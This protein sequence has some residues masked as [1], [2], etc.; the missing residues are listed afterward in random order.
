M[1]RRVR[2]AAATLLLGV[3]GNGC[4]G[5]APPAPPKEEARAETP[6]LRV[7]VEPIA[8]GGL[9]E[10]IVVRGRVLPDRDVTFSAETAGRVEALTVDSGDRVRKGEVLARI[11]YALQV[12]QREQAAAGHE[13]AVKTLER[14][15]ALRAD[16]M[17]SQQELDQ[18][19]TQVRTS[20]AA[21]AIA[22]AQLTKSVVRSTITGVVAR[23]H[24]EEGEYASPGLPLVQV[25]DYRTVIVA[26]QV[27]ET[28]AVR[29]GR[30]MPATVR[31]DALGREV[32]G[33]V[34]VLMPA[35]DAMSNT[36]ELRVRVE[37]PD[38]SVLI[39]MAATVSV[40][41]AR[42]DGAIVVAQDSVVESEEG[43]SVF[44]ESGGTARRRPVVLGAVEG[45]RVVV[46]EGLSPGDKLVVEGQ[47]SLHDGEPV[48]AVVDGAVAAPPRPPASA[49]GT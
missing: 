48:R 49:E 47:R 1:R 23:R 10:R 27:P 4:S 9:T 43:H 6:A 34:H 36:Y 45:D 33:K 2:T 12:A 25:V 22:E 39:G 11:D 37:N 5:E 15:V 40:D 28:D 13:L 32:E 35:A 7:R 14:L 30:G 3:V 26:A 21:L 19:A 24:A 38:H 16:D 17:V 29:V 42:H 18:A 46:L 41:A 44:V 20:K 31:F 8:L